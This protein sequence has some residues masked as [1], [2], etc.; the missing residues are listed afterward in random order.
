MLQVRDGSPSDTQRGPRAEETRVRIEDRIAQELGVPN[1]KV[2]AAVRLLDEGHTVP[3]IARYRKE[4]TG[5]LDDAQLRT[6]DQRLGALRALEAERSR[7]LEAIREQGKL[8]PELEQRL[9][10]AD[11]LARV[12]DLWLPYR[13]KRR[14]R[15]QAAIEAGLEPLADAL[16]AHPERAPE[17]QAAAYV[18][19]DKEVPDVDAALTGARDI[20]MQR[21][22]EDADLVERCREH[23][24]RDGALRSELR[25]GK[26]AEGAKFRDWFN[27]QEPW[28][29]V[30]S[31]RALAMLR[32][33]TEEVLRVSVVD[34]QDTED[35]PAF[36]ERFIAERFGLD[37]RGRPGDRWLRTAA[38]LCWRAKLGVRVEVSLIG[39]MKERAEAEAIRVFADNLRDLLLAAPAGPKVVLGLDPGI[40]TGVKVAVVDDTGKLLAT[41]T[42]YPHPPKRDVEGSLRALQRLVERHDVQLISI[43]NGTGSRETD[44]LAAELLQR[45]PGRALTKVVV[46]EAGASVYS[47]SELAS[48]ELPGVDVSLRGAVSIARRLQDPLAELVKIEPRSIGVGQYQHDVSAIELAQALD[49][50]VE[51]CVNAV[52]VD[53]NTASPALLQ[54][55]AGL[56]P[57]LAQAVVEWRNQN[58]AYRDRQ[59]LLEVRRLGP[60]TFEECAGFL[61]IRGGDNPLDASAVHPEAYPV[62]QR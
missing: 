62:V 8:T 27:F 35:G 14:T 57:S 21:F 24:R 47:A 11:S 37:D 19:P 30:P 23:L 10:E 49:A 12:A 15:A 39:E 33:Q 13:P 1:T 55:V 31:H 50:V 7:V 56:T 58:G 52:G 9:L 45:M 43:G 2:I 44:R 18:A 36:G 3:F 4:A 40:R 6:L 41:D 16:L 20:L 25:E 22:A 5:Q 28:S 60:R 59:Q 48:D 61:R 34:P 46:N 17:A 32:G 38:R 54:R 42:I 26:E 29:Q 51:D 53:L